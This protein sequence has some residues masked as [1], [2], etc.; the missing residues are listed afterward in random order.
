MKNILYE[1]FFVP[2]K[3][4][5]KHTFRIMK[6]AFV[7]LFILVSGIFATET[8]SQTMKVSIIAKNIS[9][10]DLMQEIEKQTDYLF[11]YKKEEIN[12]HRKVNVNA[13]DKTVAEV[14]N[15]VFKQTDIVYAIEGSNIML[16]KKG[17]ENLPSTI[18][19]QKGRIINGVIIDAKGETI[20]GANVSV[21]GTTIG[22]IT[23]IEG[24]FNLNIPDNA[25]L[26]ISYIGYISQEIKYLIKE[27]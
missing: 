4:N 24:K 1:S 18:T 10:E 15:Q 7:Y 20:I 17:K 3:L 12:L 9:T 5:F 16:M 2:L 13:T 26:L 21:K 14:L 19:Q 22:T 23:D 8:A 25:T 6:L 27:T 11:V